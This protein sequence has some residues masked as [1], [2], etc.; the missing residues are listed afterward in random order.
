MVLLS[1]ARKV[2]S[3][4]RPTARIHRA[5]VVACHVYCSLTRSVSLFNTVLRN[6]FL[7][8]VCKFFMLAR[9]TLFVTFP[10]PFYIILGT[11]WLY[12]QF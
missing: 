4:I 11:I 2:E 3:K 9:P 10:K 1:D 8:K 7:F 5:P 12:C 6:A